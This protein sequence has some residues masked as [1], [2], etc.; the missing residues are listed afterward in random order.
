MIWPRMQSWYCDVAGA[1]VKRKTLGDDLCELL[2][3]G[4]A[5]YL[6]RLWTD[7]DSSSTTCFVL[8]VDPWSR[9]I[10]PLRLSDLNA[11]LDLDLDCQIET[12]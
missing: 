1:P 5:W 3:T 4:I 10:I 12:V 2:A 6:S 11:L 9:N 7:S 8:S